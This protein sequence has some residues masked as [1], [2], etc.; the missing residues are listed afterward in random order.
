MVTTIR[1]GQANYTVAN[2]GSVPAGMHIRDIGKF[3]RDLAPRKTP[4]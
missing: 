2:G 4:S 3:A 1:G